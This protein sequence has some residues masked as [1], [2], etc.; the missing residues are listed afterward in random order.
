[1]TTLSIL[2]LSGDPKLIVLRNIVFTNIVFI[3]IM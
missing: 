1:M 3:N 2:W